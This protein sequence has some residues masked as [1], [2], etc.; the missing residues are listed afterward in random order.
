M[1]FFLVHG[2]W[3]ELYFKANQLVKLKVNIIFSSF[4][5]LAEQQTCPFQR[6][7]LPATGFEY[8]CFN[9]FLKCLCQFFCNKSLQPDTSRKLCFSHLQYYVLPLMIS[10]Y[11]IA[12][13]SMIFELLEDKGVCSCDLINSWLCDGK[14]LLTSGSSLLWAVS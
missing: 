6:D 14:Y 4:N 7:H 5:V 9:I 3:I 11:D 10:F 1:L 12:N 8:Y 13:I 2:S